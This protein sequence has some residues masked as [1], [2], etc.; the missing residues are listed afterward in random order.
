MLSIETI[1]T[2]EVYS[3]LQ[4]IGKELNV[5]HNAG[6]KLVGISKDKL[7]DSIV[8]WIEENLTDATLVD[9]CDY[10][11]TPNI[12]PISIENVEIKARV[13]F[14]KINKN[15]TIEEYLEQVPDNCYET[16]VIIAE[17]ITLSDEDFAEFKHSLLSDYEWL[18]GKGG[19]QNCL[20]VTSL[21]GDPL[22]VD[23]QGHNYPRYVGFLDVTEIEETKTETEIEETVEIKVEETETIDEAETIE[24]ETE[25]EIIDKIETTPEETVETEVEETESEEIEVTEIEEK[26]DNTKFH[27]HVTPD[28][29]YMI[30]IDHAEGL[31]LL[32]DVSF[33]G[34]TKIPMEVWESLK[35]KTH[36]M[37]YSEWLELN[38]P[39]YIPT[40]SEWLSSKG[41]N[42]LWQDTG[43]I[44]IDCRLFIDND[45]Y[46][47][48]NKDG[49]IMSTMDSQFFNPKWFKSQDWEAWLGIEKKSSSRKSGGERKPRVFNGEKAVPAEGT[50][51]RIEYDL[52]LDGATKEEV[53]TA[54]NWKSYSPSRSPLVTKYGWA[55]KNIGNGVYKLA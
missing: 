17:K 49:A 43:L 19:E 40:I 30:T 45:K 3:E 48:V 25:T 20:L 10:F 39:V 32:A 26:E 11:P 47:A 4:A 23:P 53:A 28:K 15:A 6:L 34:I 44:N 24:A 22:V 46:Y 13:K 8:T 41:L 14:P 5:A 54:L 42:P 2:C 16:D 21:N 50:K 27:I 12:E 55:I 38:T 7:R 35:V 36:I 29:K 9:A 33:N 52:L 51:L 37:L 31:I 1:K 18:A